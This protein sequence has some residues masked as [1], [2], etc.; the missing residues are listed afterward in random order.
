HY[1]ATTKKGKGIALL[2][3][4]RETPLYID[5]HPPQPG[6]PANKKNAQLFFTSERALSAES[7]KILSFFSSR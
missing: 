4:V 7:F 3:V 2:L 6:K 5:L 1:I